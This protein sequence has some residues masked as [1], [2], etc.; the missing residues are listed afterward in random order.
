MDKAEEYHQAVCQLSA[1]LA[2]LQDEKA[3]LEEAVLGLREECQ[4]AGIRADAQASAL[5]AIQPLLE[6]PSRPAEGIYAARDLSLSHDLAGVDGCR[7]LLQIPAAAR[8]SL[9]TCAWLLA[10]RSDL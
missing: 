6:D 9:N 7:G 8:S 3:A 2:Q 4:A 5:Q 10:I 1:Q